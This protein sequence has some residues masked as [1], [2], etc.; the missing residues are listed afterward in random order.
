MKKILFVCVGVL[1]SLSI[2][3]Q[4]ALNCSQP[5]A[6]SLSYLQGTPCFDVVTACNNAGYFL[7]CEKINQKGL[8]AACFNP[9]VKKGATVAGVTTPAD[10]GACKTYCQQ[11]GCK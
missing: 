8:L 6:K 2:H 1:V 7:G 9:I 3:A 4:A 5:S 11:N 10:V